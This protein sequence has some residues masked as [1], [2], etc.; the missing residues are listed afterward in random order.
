MTRIEPW[1]FTA[2]ETEDFAALLGEAS[3]TPVVAGARACVG[4]PEGG[5]GSPTDYLVADWVVRSHDVRAP[6]PGPARLHVAALP[7]GRLAV[8]GLERPEP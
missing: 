1:A 3:P 4:L 6:E 2:A 5:Q 7:S 8:V